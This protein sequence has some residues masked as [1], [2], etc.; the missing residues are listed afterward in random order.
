MSYTYKFKAGYTRGGTVTTP[1]AAPTIDIIDVVAGTLVVNAGTP[2]AG[3]AIP[4]FYSYNYSGTAN[5]DFVAVFKTI[6][7]T[8]D[9]MH[10]FSMPHTVEVI[11]AGAIS[12]IYNLKDN[13]GANVADA[14][15]WVTSD[16]A[17]TNVLASGITDASG[18]VT[19]LLDAG[20]VYVWGQKSGYN[21]TNPD[22][23]VVS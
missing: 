13:N 20:T 14:S 2:T 21:F 8:T 1:S 7:A 22:T 4:G 16:I 23:E 17:G 18:N 9:Q 12:W 10:L 6:D 3:T 11:A 15:I 19:F 5:M